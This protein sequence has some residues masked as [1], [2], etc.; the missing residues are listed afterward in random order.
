QLSIKQWNWIAFV[1]LILVLAGC[2]WSL[3]KYTQNV[4][5]INRDYL[6]AKVMPTPLENDHVRFS[7]V[8]AI[9][10]ILCGILIKEVV[11]RKIKFILGVTGSVFMVYLHILS[12]RTGLFSLYIFL[13]AGIIY[14]IIAF[15]KKSL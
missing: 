6:R 3:W 1:F 15:K 7:L 2:G 9:A 12:A 11:Q 8:V 4:E 13:I 14:L 5:I 10:V